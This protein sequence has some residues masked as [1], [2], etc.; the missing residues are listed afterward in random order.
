M[1]T[2]SY[3]GDLN[4]VDQTRH[5]TEAALR[6]QLADKHARLIAALDK[7]QEI[8]DLVGGYPPQT[9]DA[10]RLRDLVWE[11]VTAE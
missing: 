9:E 11:A 4:G 2:A 7:L 8:R 5:D 6:E 3:S 1:P 10:T